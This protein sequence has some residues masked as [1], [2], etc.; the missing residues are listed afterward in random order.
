MKRSFLLALTPLLTAASLHSAPLQEARV[1]RIIND[2]S[3]IK[4]A[5][6]AR[7]AALNELIKDDT[8]VKTGIK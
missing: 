5:D 8:A 7:A 1:A 2:V 6:G 3:V 4:P